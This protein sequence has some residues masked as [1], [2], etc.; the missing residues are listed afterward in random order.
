MEMSE[1]IAEKITTLGQGLKDNVEKVKRMVAGIED[2]LKK[3]LWRMRR[4]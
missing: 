2:N 4:S 3:N 1:A